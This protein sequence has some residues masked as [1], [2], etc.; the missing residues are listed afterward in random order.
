[1]AP[2]SS[3]KEGSVN[4]GI[5][6]ELC[7]LS[8]PT[9]DDA[10][11]KV[12]KLGSGVLLAKIHIEHAYRNMLVNSDDRLL[13]AMQMGLEDLHRHSTAAR[14]RSASK[15]LSVLADALEWILLQVGVMIVLH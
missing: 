11:E 4:A 2:H 13:L 14:L 10:V 8:Y 15:I 3:S 9:V 7:S 1:M 12:L 5:Y 6:W